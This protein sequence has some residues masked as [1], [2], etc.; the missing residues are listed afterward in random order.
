[1][2][3]QCWPLKEYLREP[4]S[5]IPESAAQVTHLILSGSHSNGETSGRAEKKPEEEKLVRVLAV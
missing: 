2:K 1:M 3:R 5:D 4:R